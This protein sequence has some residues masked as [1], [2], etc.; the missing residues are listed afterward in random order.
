MING[1]PQWP[2]KIFIEPHIIHA[3][4]NPVKLYLSTPELYQW[5][6]I[7]IEKENTLNLASNAT[8]ILLQVAPKSNNINISPYKYIKINTIIIVFIL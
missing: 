8:P 4:N 3:I 5:I 6:L 2:S 7:G 1:V